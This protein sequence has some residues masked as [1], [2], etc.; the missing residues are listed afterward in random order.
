MRLRARN[1][2]S[3]RE[4]GENREPISLIP[5]S[6]SIRNERRAMKAARMMSLRVLSSATI[7]RSFSTGT[8]ITSPPPLTTPLR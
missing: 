2:R 4:S 5:V 1:S 6:A 7:S 8:S 3:R